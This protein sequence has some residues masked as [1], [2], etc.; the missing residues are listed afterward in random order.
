MYFAVVEMYFLL[1]ESITI[2]VIGLSP[3]SEKNIYRLKVFLGS[4]GQYVTSNEKY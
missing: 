3:H 2:S 1:I 4:Y